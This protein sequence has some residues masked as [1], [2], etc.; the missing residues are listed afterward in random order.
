MAAAFLRKPDLSGRMRDTT[1]NG[2]E[3]AAKLFKIHKNSL[4]HGDDAK[5]RAATAPDAF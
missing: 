4:H 1:R 2:K 3:T 5:H